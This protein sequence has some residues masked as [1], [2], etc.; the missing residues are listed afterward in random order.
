MSVFKIKNFKKMY[1]TNNIMK[2]DNKAEKKVTITTILLVTGFMFTW[3]PYALVCLYTAF[4]NSKRLDDIYETLPAIFA[5]TSLLW[6]SL[7][8]IYSNRNIKNNIFR[9]RNRSSKSF[10]SEKSMHMFRLSEQIN[11]KAKLERF[12]SFFSSLF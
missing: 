4:I 3:S 5:K 2:R 10:A 12:E 11:K 7:H 8:Y 9:E 6:T 1:M